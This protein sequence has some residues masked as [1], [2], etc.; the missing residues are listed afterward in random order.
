[1]LVAV[2]LAACAGGGAT[3]R[4]VMAK[5]DEDKLLAAIP[6][7]IR[8]RCVAESS[9][10]PFE[11]EEPRSAV[12]G[13]QGAIAGFFCSWEPAS[14]GA[15]SVSLTYLLFPDRSTMYEDYW[16]SWVPDTRFGSHCGGE[17]PSEFVIIE[18]AKRAGRVFCTGGQFQPE[19]TWTEDD[20]LVLTH[21]LQIPFSDIGAAELYT[22]WLNWQPGAVVLRVPPPRSGP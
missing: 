6:E 22:W 9:G 1:M 20:S 10:N 18:D 3:R 15:G 12:A 4:G 21:A 11:G 14:G 17:R 5:E 16:K 13:H 19:I 8:E 7:A 2:T